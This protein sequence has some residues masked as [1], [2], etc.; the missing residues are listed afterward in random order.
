MEAIGA[1]QIFLRSAD[2]RSLRYTQY[3]GDEDSASFKKVSEAKLY[4]EEIDIEKLECVGHVQK[5]CGT[6]LRKIINVKGKS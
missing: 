4:G 2:S 6:R 5:R 3:W 1:A